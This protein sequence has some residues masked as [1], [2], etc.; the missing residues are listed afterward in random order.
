MIP[1]IDIHSSVAVYTQIENHIKFAIASGRLQPG[2]RLPTVSQLSE[3]LNV[4]INTVAKAY[5]DLKRMDYITSRRGVG[6]F[7]KERVTTQCGK[8]VR[9]EL[10]AK[11]HEITSEAQTAG[12]TLEDIQQLVDKC[13]QQDSTPYEPTPLALLKLAKQRG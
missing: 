8:E 2:D 12:M 9:I 5:R 1:N 13:M 11:L 10:I 6:Y 7:V 3:Q 4:N